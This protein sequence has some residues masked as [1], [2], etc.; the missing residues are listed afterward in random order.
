MEVDQFETILT[1]RDYKNKKVY[2]I[3]KSPYGYDLI[4]VEWNYTGKP[5]D[6]VD[7]ILVNTSF[8]ECLNKLFEIL[9][10]SSF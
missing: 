5:W 2:K 9:S 10:K 6:Y 7:P 4:F 1:V 8:N 3:L